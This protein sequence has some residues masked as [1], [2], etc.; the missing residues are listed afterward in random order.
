MAT[1]KVRQQGAPATESASTSSSISE[2]LS[3]NTSAAARAGKLTARSSK[4]SPLISRAPLALLWREPLE[5]AGA[6]PLAPAHLWRGLLE[7]LPWHL[8]TSGAIRAAPVTLSLHAAR[9]WR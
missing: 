6:R 9:L 3:F 5:A 4:N 1:L 2:S 7:V 8:R